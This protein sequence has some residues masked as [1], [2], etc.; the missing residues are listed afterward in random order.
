[1]GSVIG[2]TSKTSHLNDGRMVSG[3]YPMIEF[4][5]E[6]GISHTCRRSLIYFLS[7]LKIGDDVEVIYPANNPKKAVVNTWDEI[8]LPALFFGIISILSIILF[9]EILRRHIVI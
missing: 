4:Y 9:F 1:M 7:S 6:K 5:D 2:T 8:F 3:T